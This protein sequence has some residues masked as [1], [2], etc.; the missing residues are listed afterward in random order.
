MKP[1]P[2]RTKAHQQNSP[3]WL[4]EGPDLTAFLVCH[5][6]YHAVTASPILAFR[7]SRLGDHITFRVFRACHC[8]LSA[9]LENYVSSHQCRMETQLTQNHNTHNIKL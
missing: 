8:Q 6:L 3:F 2:L 4:A 5:I 9:V 1:R 7:D